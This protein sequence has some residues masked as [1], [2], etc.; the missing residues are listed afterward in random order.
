[1]Y[2]YNDNYMVVIILLVIS[3]VY[4]TKYTKSITFIP[5]VSMVVIIVNLIC[6]K[7]LP[8][9]KHFVLMFRMEIK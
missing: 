3:L 4:E 1:M 9:L 7:N 8:F 5:V 2:T 6:N